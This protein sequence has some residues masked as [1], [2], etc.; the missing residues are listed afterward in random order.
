LPLPVPPEITMLS[1]ACTPPA[2]VPACPA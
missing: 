2:A 1:R